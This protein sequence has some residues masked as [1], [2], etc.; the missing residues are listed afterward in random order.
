MQRVGFGYDSHRFAT[1][2][3][4]VL[5]GVRIEHDRGLEGHSDADAALHA[6]TDA[7]LGALALGDIGSLFADTDPRWK[8]AD[9]AIFVREAVRRAGEKGFTVANC[10]VTILAEAPRLAP[11]RD[12]MRRNIAAALGAPA[13]AVS[14]KAKSNEQMGFV[15]RGEGVAAV[16]VVMMETPG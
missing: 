4:L 6:V 13:G 15:G 2:R 9:S 12:A 7:V 3:P 10:D 8:G 14:V 16:A 11:H 1:G 5:G